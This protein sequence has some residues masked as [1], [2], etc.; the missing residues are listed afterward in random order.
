MS[1]VVRKPVFDVSEQARQ[2]LGCIATKDDYKLEILD[3]AV[4]AQ[5]ICGFVLAYAKKTGFLMTQLK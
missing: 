3:M 2:K 4:Y 1:S 5:L